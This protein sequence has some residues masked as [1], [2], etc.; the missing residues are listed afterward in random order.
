MQKPKPLLY[1][2]KGVCTIS[3]KNN[4]LEYR[5]PSFRKLVV[6]SEKKWENFNW[7]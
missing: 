6:F 5:S 3:K 1:I 2:K 4:E 7:A